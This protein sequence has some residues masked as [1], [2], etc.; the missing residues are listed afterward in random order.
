MGIG[1]EKSTDELGGGKGQGAD[2][3]LAK[4]VHGFMNQPSY[5]RHGLPRIHKGT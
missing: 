4:M 3:S 1:K 5:S 2:R